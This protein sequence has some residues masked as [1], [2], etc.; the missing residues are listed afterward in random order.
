MPSGHIFLNVAPITCGLLGLILAC[1]LL[2]QG[3]WP[4]GILAWFSLGLFTAGL[5]IVT[6]CPEL[7]CKRRDGTLPSIVWLYLGGWL[8]LYRGWHFFKWSLPACGLRYKAGDCEFNA[9]VPRLLL[10]RLLWELPDLPGPLEVGMVIDM[11]CEWSEPEALRN[12]DHYI[13]VPVV[14]TTRP[15]VEQT[16][17]AARR[18]VAF[19]RDHNAGSVY[20][21][22][23]NGYGRS[24]VIVAAVLL[25]D[26][27]CK[28]P[29]EAKE[30]VVQ[31]RTVASLRERRQKSVCETMTHMEILQAIAD[32][33]D[34]HTT[35]SNFDAESQ[36]DSEYSSSDEHS[37]FC[38]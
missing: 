16:S 26:G 27:T 10:G 25:L 14:D 15:T 12:V 20:V 1:V 6:D 31:A 4:A 28:T 2:F 32:N 38:C 37:A 18:A 11:T 9:I 36:P 29:A 30:L 19:L 35:E 3:V 13:C 17:F 8:L 24:A 34:D 7:Y 23:A 33:L 22:C 5:A 21:H